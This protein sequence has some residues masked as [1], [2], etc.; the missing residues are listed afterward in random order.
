M[1]LFLV[2]LFC[3]IPALCL[4]QIYSS[5]SFV[6]EN[7]TLTLAGGRSISAS[8]EY[9]SSVGE[10]VQGQSAGSDF[11]YRAGF[12][13]FPVVTTPMLSATTGDSQVLLSWTASAAELGWNVSGYAVGQSTSNGGPYT[14]STVGNVLGVV[15]GGLSNGTPYYFVVQTLDTFGNV[16]A[17]SSQ[18]SATPVGST[19]STPS[20]GGGG[21]GGATPSGASV[22]FSGR[23][24]PN[25]TITL[26][27]DAQV[28][29]T[30][31]AG[32]DAKFDIS[33]ASLSSGTFIFSLYS[34]DGKGNR[35]ALVTIPI[36]LAAG[37]STHVSGIFI[38]PTIGVDKTQ[39]RRGD[40]LA[41]FG[42]S[43][44]QGEVT[45][46]VHSG[47]EIIV[48]TASDSDGIYLYNFD[49]TP[50]ELGNH[51]TKSRVAL[52][53][54][55]VSTFGTA[56]AFKIGTK[57]IENIPGE[58]T[59][60]DVNCDGRVNLIDFSIVA[61]WYRRPLS[62]VFIEVEKKYLNGDGNVDIVDFSIMAYYWSG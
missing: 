56:V 25:S 54:N 34:Q 7:P 24:Y 61:Y 19:T 12:L 48:K 16:I 4:A 35:S 58:C 21:G 62:P 60:G 14:F 8:F 22:T 57:T 37:A 9:Y 45:I 51:S 47:E 44:P 3:F 26:L 59:K 41:I 13:Y 50:L 27:K 18:A 36:T 28:A 42:R 30:T 6:L 29:V 53:N 43:A 55:E 52:E 39:V 20:G 31:V 17:T 1:R 46:S 40:N 2:L 32:P 11:M 5:S 33:L 10:T 15:Q 38:T 49:T 23:A